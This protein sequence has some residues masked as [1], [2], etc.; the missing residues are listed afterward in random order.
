MFIRRSFDSAV[1]VCGF[2]SLYAF[3][4]IHVETAIFVMCF[5]RLSDAESGNQSDGLEVLAV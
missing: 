5:R 2:I 4:L 1:S 3:C